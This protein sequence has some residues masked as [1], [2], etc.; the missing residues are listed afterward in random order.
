MRKD[1]NFSVDALGSELLPVHSPDKTLLPEDENQE[2]MLKPSS[3][4]AKIYVPRPQ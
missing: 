3:I 2:A 1:V 4:W